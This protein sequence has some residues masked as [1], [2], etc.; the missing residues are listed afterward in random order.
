MNPNVLRGNEDGVAFRC[1]REYEDTGLNEGDVRRFD[2][3]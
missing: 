3:R 1:V 2:V